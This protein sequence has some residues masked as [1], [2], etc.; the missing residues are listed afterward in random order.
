[1]STVPV[2]SYTRTVLTTL[3]ISAAVMKNVVSQETDVK[4]VSARS[5]SVRR[6][7]GSSTRPT[8]GPCGKV[9]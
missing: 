4:G 9:A 2:G 3:G 6:T 8:S 5:S 1:M 7:P